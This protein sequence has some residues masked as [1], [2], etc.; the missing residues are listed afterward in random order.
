MCRAQP[1]CNNGIRNRDL[2][3]RLRL[4]SK[5]D[6]NKTFRETLGVEIAKRIAEYSVRILKMNVRT[7]WRRQPP[8]NKEET[9]NNR[10]RERDVRT[11]AILGTFAYADR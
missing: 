11:L 2:K 1:E 8:P 10:L 9:T 6:I 3:E 7:L 4:G 5:G